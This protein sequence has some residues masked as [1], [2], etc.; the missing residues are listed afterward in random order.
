MASERSSTLVLATA[1]ALIP[2]CESPAGYVGW[3]SVQPKF[4]DVSANLK[5]PLVGVA[6]EMP[7]KPSTYAELLL[8]GDEAVGVDASEL[9]FGFRTRAAVKGP[10]ELRG[11]LDIGIAGADVEGFLNANTLVSL[12]AAARPSVRLSPSV[13][14]VGTFGYRYYFDTTEPTTCN[15]GSQSSSIGSGT[16]SHHGGIAHYNDYVGDGGGIELSIGVSITF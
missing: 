7:G 10:I 1:L 8:L 14:I 12:G 15:D 6:S 13:A 9:R 2:S 11:Q 4:D 5:G 16:C 3:A